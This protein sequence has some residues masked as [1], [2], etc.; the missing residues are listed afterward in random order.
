MEIC[1]G[2]RVQ[3]V[4]RE[5]PLPLPPFFALIATTVSPKLWEP[6]GAWSSQAILLSFCTILIF[7]REDQE[8]QEKPEAFV[9]P[10]R[11]LVP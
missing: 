1:S 3:A 10:Y 7:A 9:L 11:T 6:G 4:T 2:L 8:F 5:V